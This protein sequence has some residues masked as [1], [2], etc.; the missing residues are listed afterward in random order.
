VSNP[1]YPFRPR[2]LRSPPPPSKPRSAWLNSAKFRAILVW[3]V[4][5]LATG[6]LAINL[7]YVQII[8]GSVLKGIAKSHQMIFL[9]PFIPR[10]DIVDRN[11][12]VLALDRP[13][14][15]LYA[16]PKLFKISK[17][18]MAESCLQF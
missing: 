6:L 7:F 13:V 14:F 3:G 2:P 18:E 12:A 11:G 17:S 8:Q 10:R 4:L 16:H 1:P 9:R 5:V 15:T